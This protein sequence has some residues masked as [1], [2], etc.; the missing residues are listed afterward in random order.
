MQEIK[1]SIQGISKAAVSHLPNKL[2][3]HT[4]KGQ[5]SQELSLIKI[6]L[7]SPNRQKETDTQEIWISPQPTDVEKKKQTY[8]FQDSHHHCL[9][10]LHT[11][12]MLREQA[13]PTPS[14]F[15]STMPASPT[16]P[17]AAPSTLNVKTPSRGY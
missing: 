7:E 16:L 14:Q 9:I 15:R 1:K 4:D 2:E 8:R 5:G 6:K 10:R 13:K 17:L 3:L 11:S 12:H